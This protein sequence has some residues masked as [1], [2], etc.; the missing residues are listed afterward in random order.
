MSKTILI[1]GA[2]DGIG[3]E[4]AGMLVKKGHHILLHGRSPDKLERVKT[5]LSKFGTVQSYIADLSDLRAV[6]RLADEIMV[7]HE[8]LDVL[9]NNAGILTLRSL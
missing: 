1:T 2:T 6:K 5:R 8:V 9:I 7:E 3:F 4:T